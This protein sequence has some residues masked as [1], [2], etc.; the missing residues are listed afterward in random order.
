MGAYF[1]DLKGFKGLRQK[2]I[3]LKKNHPKQAAFDAWAKPKIKHNM[4]QIKE[5]WCLQRIEID[6]LF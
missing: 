1:Q 5:N 6:I 2:T 4:I 3:N